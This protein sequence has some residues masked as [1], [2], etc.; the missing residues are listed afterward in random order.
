[1]LLPA[2]FF[3]LA[4][5]VRDFFVAKKRVNPQPAQTTISNLPDPI[6]PPSPGK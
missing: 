2:K 1:M 5:F 6:K 3:A 4:S